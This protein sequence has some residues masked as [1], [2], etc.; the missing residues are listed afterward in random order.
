MRETDLQTAIVELAELLGWRWIHHRPARTE[1]GWRT[2]V[3]GSHARGWPDLVLCRERLVVAELK[4]T[5]G[6]LSVEQS[7]WISA[8]EAAGVEAYVWWPESWTDIETTLTRKE[9]TIG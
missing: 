5:R 9:T 6:Q 3:S 7:G 8:L 1:Q 2:A 4:G